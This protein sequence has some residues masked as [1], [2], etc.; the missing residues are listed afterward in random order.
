MMF[1]RQRKPLRGG[2]KKPEPRG[3]EV[4]LTSYDERMDEITQWNIEHTDILEILRRG[5]KEERLI[6]WSNALHIGARKVL[7][8]PEHARGT[9]E[10]DAWRDLDQ[11]IANQRIKLLGNPSMRDARGIE[12]VDPLSVCI[13]CGIRALQR[14]KG[15]PGAMN[16]LKLKLLERYLG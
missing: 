12:K 2:G 9:P 15:L 16:I 1:F 13:V 8:K 4:G 5:I 6:S 14:E 7:K 3:G 10:Y 11:F